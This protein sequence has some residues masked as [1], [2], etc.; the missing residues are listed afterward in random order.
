MKCGD[1]LV[2]RNLL[3]NGDIKLNALEFDAGFSL[4]TVQGEQT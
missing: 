3:S 4:M 1:C 2:E